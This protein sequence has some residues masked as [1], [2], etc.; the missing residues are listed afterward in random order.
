MIAFLILA[1]TCNLAYGSLTEASLVNVLL[2]QGRI[3][4][5]S[6]HGNTGGVT[7]KPDPALSNRSYNH[8]SQP[9]FGSSV[10]HAARTSSR[11]SSS[12]RYTPAAPQLINSREVATYATRRAA[13]LRWGW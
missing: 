13:G 2:L 1:S 9:L 11:S 10:S 4:L 6:A 8:S 7:F 3:T 12:K 5:P